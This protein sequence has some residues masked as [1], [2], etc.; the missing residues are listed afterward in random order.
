[1]ETILSFGTKIKSIYRAGSDINSDGDLW[2]TADPA[3]EEDIHY[4]KSITVVAVCGQ[5][6]HVPWARMVMKDG[7]ITDFNLADATEIVPLE[8]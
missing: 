7:S 2:Y 4:V 3:R 5:M 6:G 1:M 8:E